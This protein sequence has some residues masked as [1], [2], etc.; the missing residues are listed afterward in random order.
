[1]SATCFWSLEQNWISQA[2]EKIA[3][4]GFAILQRAISIFQGGCKSQELEVI[5]RQ[6]SLLLV[7]TFLSIQWLYDCDEALE[8]VRHLKIV[9]D[10]GERK[11]ARL[12]SVQGGA[13][14]EPWVTED[15]VGVQ[16]QERC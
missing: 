13:G 1:M 8:G 9:F 5:Y 4:F 6:D 16:G 7:W 15:T 14:R 3:F 11:E 2:G 12:I 10:K